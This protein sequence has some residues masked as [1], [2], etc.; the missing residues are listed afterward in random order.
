M[1]RFKLT[2]KSNKAGCQGNSGDVIDIS[3]ED[4]ADLQRRGCGEIVA[5]RPRKPRNPRKQDKTTTKQGP[6]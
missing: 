3:S 2:H 6:D 4:A 1:I 5:P